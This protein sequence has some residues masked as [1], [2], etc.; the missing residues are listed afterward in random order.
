MHAGQIIQYKIT[1]LP[2]VRMYWETEITEVVEYQSFTD[3]QRVGPYSYWS[4][5]HTFQEVKGGIEMI[6]ELEYSIP[7]GMFGRMANYLFVA[8]QVKN[9]FN[10][11]F[12]VLEGLFSKPL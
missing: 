6:D 5:K 2:F 12:Q 7:F 10:Y 4:H 8:R 1:V 11:R 9:I 3:I